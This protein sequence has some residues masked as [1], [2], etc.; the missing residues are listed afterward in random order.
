MTQ[1]TLR[2]LQAMLNTLQFINAGLA[3]VHQ[4]PMIALICGGVLSGFS[5]YVHS[6]AAD[7][8]PNKPQVKAAGA[9]E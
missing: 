8:E 1:N 5:Q 6:C 3:A 9:G 4:S 7:Q 2:F